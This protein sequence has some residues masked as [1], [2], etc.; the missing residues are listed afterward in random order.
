MWPHGVVVPA[1]FLDDDLGL[2]EGVEDL[3]VEQLVPEPGIEA[4]AIAVFPRRSRFDVGGLRTDGGNPVAD[5]F[6][7]EL[8]AVVGPDTQVDIA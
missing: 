2:L 3:A 8:G 5:S 6:G 4:L 1:P 7:D